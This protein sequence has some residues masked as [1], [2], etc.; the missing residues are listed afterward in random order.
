MR[1]ER[2]EFYDV[3]VIIGTGE[4][5]PDDEPPYAVLF[6]TTKLQR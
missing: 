6:P 2:G 4:N 1:A 3:I 5:R